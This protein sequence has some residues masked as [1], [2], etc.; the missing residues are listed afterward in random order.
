MTTARAAYLTRRRLALETA[1]G[2][3]V[4]ETTRPGDLRR[5][6]IDATTY[7]GD[8]I[9]T[10]DPPGVGTPPRRSYRLGAPRIPCPVCG[11]PFI[12][13]VDGLIRRHERGGRPCPGSRTRPITTEGPTT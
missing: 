4:D 11:R 1:V 9:R 3:L 5:A 2:R 6:A 13:T 8:I 7:L 10:V 12:P